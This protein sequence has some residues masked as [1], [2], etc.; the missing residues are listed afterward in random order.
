MALWMYGFLV[1]S[2]ELSGQNATVHGRNL[3]ELVDCGVCK[4]VPLSTC[5]YC[6]AGSSSSSPSQPRRR[7]ARRRRTVPQL[8]LGSHEPRRRQPRRRSPG[9][10]S[11]SPSQPR[12]R[13]TGTAPGNVSRVPDC[14]A[15][16]RNCGTCKCVPPSSCTWCPGGS[17]T[18]NV[19]KAP[20]NLD[21]PPGTSNSVDLITEKL[22]APPNSSMDPLLIVTVVLLVSCG[23]FG[24]G[25]LWK[26]HKEKQNVEGANPDP[27]LQPA[28][29]HGQVALPRQSQ[30]PTKPSLLALIPTLSVRK[31]LPPS[32][33]CSGQISAQWPRRK[34]AF[35]TVESGSFKAFGHRYSI[36]DPDKPQLTKKFYWAVG[37]LQ[38]LC[39]IDRNTIEWQTNHSNPEWQ[40]FL[41][42]C[43]FFPN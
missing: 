11:A 34:V 15:S 31:V 16:Y 5:K 6:H 19:T 27:E 3:E 21:I 17:T 43:A 28:A 9:G 36:E 37:T 39:R 33:Q 13:R 30:S 7:R 2:A 42:V 35:F 22:V 4:A 38:T 1:V 14:P 8:E 24:A 10:S 18:T 32:V 41:W 40:R 20:I 26:R 23:A 12:R 25:C 29:G